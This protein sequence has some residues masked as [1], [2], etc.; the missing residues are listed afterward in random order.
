[1]SKP[2]IV[3]AARAIDAK[4]GVS[5]VANALNQEF[6]ASGYKT[7]TFTLENT[8]LKSRNHLNPVLNKLQLIFDITWTS[9]VGTLLLRK[10]FNNYQHCVIC[11]ND[12]MFGD[13]YVN[14]G[15]HKALL[16]QSGCWKMILRN[17]IHLFLLIRETLRHRLGIHK[18]VVCFSEQQKKEFI[19]YFPYQKAKVVIIPNGIDLNRFNPDQPAPEDSPMKGEHGEKYLLFVGYEFNRKGLIHAIN[20]LQFLPDN[21]HLVA[22]GGDDQQIEKFAKYAHSKKL[23]S[24]LVFTGPRYDVER[25]YAAADCFVLPADFEPWGLV[26]L[27][28][29]ACGTPVIMTKVGSSMDFLKPGKNGY[30]CEQSDE[31][32]AHQILASQSLDQKSII[33][34]VKPFSWP[35][36]AQR[37]EQ[38]FDD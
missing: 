14:H 33:E 3:N 20:A 34:S 1:M 6:T 24:R 9:T 11:H 8:G 7:A 31:N 36:I 17:P 29:M 25:L 38:L 16:M 12:F 35:A 30:F 5:N 13:I 19:Q 21:W 28:A 22:V 4:G 15:L 27:E 2:L 18:T 10:K 23:S 37:Y 26:A 32:I